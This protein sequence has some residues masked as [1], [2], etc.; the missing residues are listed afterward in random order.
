MTGHL[1]IISQ[2]PIGM[3]V[4]L[5]KQEESVA[6]F[7]R[8]RWVFCVLHVEWCNFSTTSVISKEIATGLTCLSNHRQE[9]SW[10]LWNWCSNV[11]YVCYLQL[12]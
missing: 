8:A 6:Y 3:R 11:S 9:I 1:S 2:F 5:K 12:R 10:L 4:W 7:S